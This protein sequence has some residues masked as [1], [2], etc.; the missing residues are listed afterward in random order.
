MTK[1][2][3]SDGNY[4]IIKN[5][6]VR[7]SSHTILNITLGG[8]ERVHTLVVKISRSSSSTYNR[9]RVLTQLKKKKQSPQNALN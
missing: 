5:M 1:Y 2:R 4:K 7:Y 3:A 8:S 6:C 9:I